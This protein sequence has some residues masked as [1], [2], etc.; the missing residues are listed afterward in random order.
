MLTVSVCLSGDILCKT[1]ICVSPPAP[2]KLGCFIPFATLPYFTQNTYLG[3]FFISTHKK[4]PVSF[5]MLK[6]IPFL[7]VS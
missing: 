1:Y 6:N 5:W 2:V 4:L 3:G 7:N